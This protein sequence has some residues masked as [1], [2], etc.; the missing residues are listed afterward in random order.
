M[1]KPKY[2][3]DLIDPRIIAGESD[4]SI[5]DDTGIP[6]VTV[7]HRR[8]HE[9]GIP[10]P[11][12]RKI[13]ENLGDKAPGNKP[14]PE[15]RSPYMHKSREE[16]LR[17]SAERKRKG[18]GMTTSQFEAWKS[19]QGPLSAFAQFR[20]ETDMTEHD[21][22]RLL[23]EADDDRDEEFAGKTCAEINGAEGSCPI[24][25]EKSCRGCRR[26]DLGNADDND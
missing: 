25:R 13:M 16:I 26:G 10:S 24:G 8:W 15:A 14:P 23:D 6:Y 7:Q 12:Q 11:K 9:F 20:R 2:N 21:Y 5:A 22:N 19:N 4:R 17:E 1:N 3:W 18:M